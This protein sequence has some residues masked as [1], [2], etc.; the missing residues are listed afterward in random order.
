MR[1]RTIKPEFW[2]NEDLAS[3]SPE[4][5]LLAIGL[6]NMADDEGY[7]NANPKLI[8]SMIFPIRD[9]SGSIT[10]LI[11]ELSEIGYLKLYE[12]TDG[13]KYGSV[14]NFSAHQ[15]INKKKPS[16]IREL[17]GV[18]Y[19]YRT[20]T[21]PVPTERKGKEGNGKERN[22]RFARPSVDDVADYCAE[23]N[24]GINPQ[25]FVDYYEANGWKVGRNPMKDWKA[26]VRTWEQSRKEKSRSKSQSGL[27]LLKEIAR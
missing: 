11:Q 8:S 3:V 4:A 5:A 21:V 24:N 15:V 1:I 19:D 6:L 20:A 14:V 17:C 23:R 10:V 18:P 22:T 13:K 12:G 27:S 2:R 25:A 26:S 9:L 7:F 16:R